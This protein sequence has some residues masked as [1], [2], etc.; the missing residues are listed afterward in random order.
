MSSSFDT[1]VA[2]LRAAAEPTRLRLLS[3]LVR[4][5]FAVSELT[6]VL[7]QSQPRVSRHL[8]L[9]DDCGMLERFREQHWI[10]YRVPADNAAGRFARELVARLDPDDPV[11]VADAQ[12]VAVL[13]E[14]RARQ[15]GSRADAADAP[16]RSHD[17]FV[18]EIARELGDGGHEALLYFGIA[19]AQVIGGIGSRARRIVGM[20]PLRQEVQRAR[21]L[22]HS[23]GLSHC[24]MQQGELRALAQPSASFETVVLDCALAGEARP[25]E[26]L[27]E[28]AR[29][30][31]Q[32]GRL[33]LVEDYDALEERSRPGNPL[34]LLRDWLGE[35]GLACLR[36][37]PVDVDGANLLLAVAAAD[38]A[39]AAA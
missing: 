10:Y 22:L 26:A 33:L 27:R 7:G 8:K 2:S 18:V 12:R 24:V 9:L 37:K 23:R 35:A 32:D 31:R 29:V 25:T 17:E 28:V 36:L 5:E 16:R 14:Q 39:L 6:Q 38:R 4:G 20:H 1:T 19:P 21:A 11:L 13:L 34:A 30:L 3:I 15:R